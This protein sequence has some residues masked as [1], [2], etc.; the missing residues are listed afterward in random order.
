M[1]PAFHDQPILELAYKLN[2]DSILY[3]LLE[4]SINKARWS[5][6]DQG[7]TVF[8]DFDNPDIWPQN[9]REYLAYLY[10]F[11]RWVPNE[12]DPELHNREVFDMLC[13]F[14][15]LINQEVEHDRIHYASLQ[16]NEW[17]SNW[18]IDF[19][20]KWGCYLDSAES[21]NPSILQSFLN[22]AQYHVADSMIDDN[23]KGLRPNNPSGWLSFNQFFARELNPGLRPVA[24]P[25]NVTVVTSPADCTFKQQFPISS[26]SKVTIKYT[27]TYSIEQLLEDSPY[28]G[29]FA[30]GVFAHC[31]LGPGDYH[32]FH[33]PV[34]GQ[35]LECRAIHGK[36]YLNVKIENGQYSAPD[37]AADGYEFSQARGLIMF[38]TAIGKV[39]VI[40]VGMCQVSSV[41]M[42]ARSG[43]DLIK[44]EE[45]GYFMFGGSDIIMLFQEKA[46]I[47][48]T[49]NEGTHYKV[50]TVVATAE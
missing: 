19:A 12:K 45:F 43:D 35:V 26:D 2:H 40:P 22:D 42:L 23:G 1:S 4:Q 6:K 50:G 32:R 36:V 46:N 47:T 39:A 37:S 34:A 7:L 9:C 33:A 3:S 18:L 41:N 30:N 11:V 8:P 44:G 16:Q 14:Y 25:D 28:Q 48:I 24:N 27:H 20:E 5:A 10:R 21:F 49:M 15:W 17:F 31:F 38:D 13:H 29:S